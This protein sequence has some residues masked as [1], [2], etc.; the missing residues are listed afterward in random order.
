M[1]SKEDGDEPC[2]KATWWVN[3]AVQHAIAD[4]I[5]LGRKIQSLQLHTRQNPTDR[6]PASLTRV[7]DRCRCGTGVAP[8]NTNS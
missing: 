3:V 8:R 5:D 7:S 1:G 6:A 4:V 2:V